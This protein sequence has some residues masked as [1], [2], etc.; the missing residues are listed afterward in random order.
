MRFSRPSKTVS[1]PA[2]GYDPASHP[3]QGRVLT[4]ITTLA[5]GVGWNRTNNPCGQLFSKESPDHS[6]LLLNAVL[7]G[8][9]PAI[10][11]LTTWCF[12]PL[13][14]RTYASQGQGIEP[15]QADLEAAVL[16][17]NY[18]CIGGWR[19]LSPPLRTLA[20]KAF[21]RLANHGLGT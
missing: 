11:T 17:L 4:T 5:H 13:N 1:L 16:P 10:S 6:V 2:A 8:F 19:E 14:N 18:P 3:L 15:R 9:E 20:P 12:K 21:P 7:T